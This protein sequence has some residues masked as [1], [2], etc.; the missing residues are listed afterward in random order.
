MVYLLEF[1]L[2]RTHP[3]CG[4]LG[5]LEILEREFS[6]VKDGRPERLALALAHEGG[7][8]WTDALPQQLPAFSPGRT[9][10]R[11]KQEL[12]TFLGKNLSFIIKYTNQKVSY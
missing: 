2:L 9:I 4:C 1:D 3:N 7:S 11:R 8:H 12:N 5:K 6:V 10:C